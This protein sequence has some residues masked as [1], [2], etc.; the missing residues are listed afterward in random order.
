MVYWRNLYVRAV[1]RE[2]F[3]HTIFVIYGRSR[4]PTPFYFFRYLS[5]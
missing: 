3:Q 5:N 1:C 4:H 2:L